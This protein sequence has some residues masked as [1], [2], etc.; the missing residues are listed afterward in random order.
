MGS[1]GRVLREE[2]RTMN[3]TKEEI[4]REVFDFLSLPETPL[5]QDGWFNVEEWTIISGKD[6]RD[7]MYKPLRSAHAEEKVGRQK[8]GHVLYYQPA[9]LELRKKM[10][11]FWREYLK[12]SQD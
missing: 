8:V 3:I 2:T 6:D 1:G 12:E 7:Q 4:A 11:D 5:W 9:D 10:I